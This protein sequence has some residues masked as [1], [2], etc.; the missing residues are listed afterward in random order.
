[1]MHLAER[2]QVNWPGGQVGAGQLAGSSDPSRQSGEL[3][4]THRPVMHLDPSAQANWS[5]PQFRAGDTVVVPFFGWRS[6]WV[7]KGDQQGAMRRR[8]SRFISRRAQGFIL[9]LLS[10]RA[11]YMIPIVK[12]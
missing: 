6:P 2:A 8:I 9:D 4:Q 5:G 7:G 11:I 1:M 12:K 10:S 3:S